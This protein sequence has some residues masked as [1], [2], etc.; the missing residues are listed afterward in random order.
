VTINDTAPTADRWNLAAVE[1][2]PAAVGF[3]RD[4]K[5]TLIGERI[6][7]AHYYYLLDSQDSVIGMVNTTCGQVA[8]YG[9]D[10]YGSARSASSSV[11]NPF[12]YVGGVYDTGTGLTKLGARYYDPS[13]ARFTQPDRAGRMRTRTLMRLATR[14]AERT[15]AVC[16][17]LIS[18]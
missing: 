17:H 4:V 10:P 7:T 9:Y 18:G 11:P 6:G 2:V 1:I 12:R 5:G 3:T 15:P 13:I 8:S 14:S 16:G